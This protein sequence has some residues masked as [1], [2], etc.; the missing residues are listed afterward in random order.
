MQMRYGTHLA[1]DWGRN[2]HI[3][4]VQY[5][6]HETG[7]AC[8]G[9]NLSSRE[10]QPTYDQRDALVITDPYRPPVRNMAHKYPP[11]VVERSDKLPSTRG[12][13]S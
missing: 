11:F 3:N 4:D 8:E 6:G 1:I 10:N 5:R 2:V 12:R 13:L 9:I 7:H